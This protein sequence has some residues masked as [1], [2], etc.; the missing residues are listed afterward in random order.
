M[1]S[2]TQ[3][4]SSG[5]ATLIL[6][7]SES[8]TSA[9]TNSGKISWS[10]QVK[11]LAASGS[12]NNGGANITVTV[13][14][15]QR[16]KGNSFSLQGVGKGSTKTIASGSFTQSHSADGSLSLSCAASFTSGVGLGNAS[17]SSKT[18]T[19]TTIPRAT[20]P[21]LSASSV[22]LGSSVTINTPRASSAFTHKLYYKIGS[23]SWVSI[24]TGVGTSYSWTVPKSIASSFPNNSSGVIVIAADTYN[25]STKIGSKQV[26]LTVK[27]PTTAE[28]MPVVSSLTVSE[29][30]SKVTEAFGSR[31]VQGLSQLNVK[32]TATGSYNSTI[33]SYSTSVDGVK[34]NSAAFTSNVIN[35]VGTIPVTVT[36]TDS[37]SRT[38]TKT[39]N[40][41]L[42]P[43]AYPVITSLSYQQCNAD[44]TASNEGTSTK[45]VISGKVASVDSQNSRT[46]TLKWR[47]SSETT[48]QIRV[49]STSD[50]EFAVETIINGTASDET[51]EFVAELADKIKTVEKEITTGTVALSFLAGGNGAK[52]GG[53]AEK[54]GLEIPWPITARGH[55][56]FVH[57]GNEFT[58]IPSGYTGGLWLNYRTQGGTNGALS[59]YTFGNGAGGLANGQF[60]NILLS[61]HGVTA[62]I[63]PQ[64]SSYVHFS[65]PV[66]F[67]FNNEI[68][69]RESIYPSSNLAKNLGTT[70]D[71]W[72]Y[73]YAKGFSATNSDG[74]YWCEDINGKDIKIMG[75]SSSNNLWLG[76]STDIKNTNIYASQNINF[77]PN[78]GG[79]YVGHTINLLR[80]QSDSTRTVFRPATN[81]VGYI[82]TTSYRWNTAFFTNAITA[83]DLKEK[84][85][86]EDFDFKAEDFILGLKPIAYRRKGEGDGGKRIHLGFGAQDVAK[87]IDDLE[88][89]N[90][91]I[92]Q[93]SITQEEPVEHENDNGEV[94]TVVERVEK[95]YDGSS[96][97]DS[98]LSWGLNYNE[99]IAPMVLM[100]QKQDKEIKELKECIAKLENTVDKTGRIW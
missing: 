57:N 97:D 48:Y 25:G 7:V 73:V 35:G 39:I 11:M 52:F 89:G 61:A 1:A 98:Q 19:G 17:I 26:N 55:H 41:T 80:E 100:I 15:V 72:K 29:S 30:V 83:S 12:Y 91:S 99:L 75:I 44:G 34:Y 76:D 42:I 94:E 71:R 87:T 95:P 23:G 70:S 33:K 9:T 32:A 8:G 60:N 28:F 38:A 53:E 88:I 65:S 68:M 93:A 54:E 24:A 85:V 16:Y 62:Q 58:F 79:T 74:G 49:L 5:W 22:N 64:N 46:L 47:K 3:N 6:N 14:G 92:V 10:L 90:L 36:V 67:Y 78:R 77:V 13:G 18:F 51:Y 2:Y 69:V 59:Q 31:Y 20:Q 50:W 37:R 56:S 96:I 43:Y 45:V 21:A 27:V 63:G 40:I 66:T 4:F 84:D 81:G 82:G 86:I